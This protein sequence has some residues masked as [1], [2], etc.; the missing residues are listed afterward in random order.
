MKAII[1]CC[2][3]AYV[4]QC[5]LH[6]LIN[7]NDSIFFQAQVLPFLAP[8]TPCHEQPKVEK[9]IY[10]YICVLREIKNTFNERKHFAI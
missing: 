7:I 9:T 2:R 1:C 10:I 4:N 6:L 3:M 5:T 8:F